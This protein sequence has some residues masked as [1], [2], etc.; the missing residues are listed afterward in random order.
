[1]RRKVLSVL[2]ILVIVSSCVFSGCKKD[3]SEPVENN[4]VQQEHTE[5]TVD[6]ENEI[7]EET[8]NGDTET[9]PYIDEEDYDGDTLIP[10]DQAELDRFT[11]FVR[12]ADAYGFLLSEY[13]SPKDVSL[14]KVFYM[15]AGLNEEAS[16]DEASAYLKATG[17]E[18][19]YTTL[20]KLD[21]QRVYD[22][23][24]KRL[25][26]D[27]KDLNLDEIGV[28]IPE[29]DAYFFEESDVNYVEYECISG[30]DNG[31]GYELEFKAVGECP[32]GFSQVRTLVTG[33]N[34]EYR[35]MWNESEELS[36]SIL[37]ENKKSGITHEDVE[38]A[39]DLLYE[40]KLS[41]YEPTEVRW[42][43]ELEMTVVLDVTDEPFEEGGPQMRCET[44]AEYNDW[45]DDGIQFWYHKAYY[46]EKDEVF[47][48]KTLGWYWVDIRTGV[49][50]EG[51]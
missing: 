18:E 27:P 19:I 38:R 23:L 12:R 30:L 9:D 48:T 49:I 1:M 17:Q 44:L 34:G 24:G 8:D 6:T 11:E 15:G 5:G 36:S 7:P 3:S 39:F 50:K 43:E 16:N 25:D 22:L 13:E 33:K 21:K 40:E 14:G 31:F 28:Y 10:L 45:G 4:T 26:C 42:G 29:Y 46:K 41:N 2:T 37:E 32:P 20:M 35:F 47:A 51:P